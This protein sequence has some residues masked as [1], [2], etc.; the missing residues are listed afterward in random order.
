MARK[1]LV[2]QVI[3]SE[4]DWKIS[5]TSIMQKYNVIDAGQDIGNLVNNIMVTQTKNLID[6][7]S[8]IKEILNTGGYDETTI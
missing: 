2:D 1:E 3:D 7:N 5:T 8:A 4:A 6:N